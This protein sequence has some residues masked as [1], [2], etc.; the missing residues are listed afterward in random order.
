MTPTGT[1]LAVKLPLGFCRECG[2]DYYV[3]ART[4]KVGGHAYVPRHDSDASG[5]DAVTGYL[6]VSD[7]HPWPADP[8]A[9][10]RVPDHWLVENDDASTS[11]A[12]NKRK[13][14]AEQVWVTPDG[15]EASPGD[16]LTAWWMSTPFAF[17]LRCRVSYEQVRGNDFPKLATLEQEGRS[18]A[19]TVLSASIV[20]SLRAFDKSQLDPMARKLLTFVDN[21]Q[22]ASL[23]ARHFND[24][25]Q[26]AQLRGALSA[27]LAKASNG[28]THEVVAQ[29]V[30]AALGL[31][32]A[33]YA[34]NPVAK[35]SQK[36]P[37][38]AP[39]DGSLAALSAAS[40]GPRRCRVR[41]G[42]CSASGG[43]TQGREPAPCR[44]GGHRRVHALRSPRRLR[45]GAPVHLYTVQR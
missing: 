25:V 42:R 14:L 4:M 41:R 34:A 39:S 6:Y 16:G 18:S 36:K 40:V 23:Q 45:A 24:F 33:D 35:F 1:M 19:V 28:L 11:V 21:R 29:E 10:G 13:C 31:D 20:R 9:E 2:Q 38:N 5:G 7:D 37:P 3:V 22:D 43:G 44:H 12:T 32:I 30:T 17:C 8:V 15:E 27:A 26:V